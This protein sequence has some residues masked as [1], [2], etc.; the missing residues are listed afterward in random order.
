MQ[1]PRAIQHLGGKHVAIS[2]ERS[3][4]HARKAR[5]GSSSI[6]EAVHP[7]R[8][9]DA[10]DEARGGNRR[11]ELARYVVQVRPGVVGRAVGVNAVDVVDEDLF[12]CLV[13]VDVV[14]FVG[15]SIALA[16][17]EAWE[18]PSVLLQAE[19]YSCQHQVLTCEIYE[20]YS[21]GLGGSCV[22]TS[23]GVYSTPMC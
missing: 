23:L 11:R 5:P 3:D 12:D 22:F 4:D 7:D 21:R 16:F 13:V 9:L 10:D 6:G 2:L 20:A 17:S 15:R 8:V 14:A 1:G 18:F 19:A